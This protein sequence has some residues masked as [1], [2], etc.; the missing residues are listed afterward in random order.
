M[1]RKGYQPMSSLA[2][3][4]DMHTPADAEQAPGE[5][6]TLDEQARRHVQFQEVTGGPP[7]TVA[8]A[9]R[10]LVA[11]RRRQRWGALPLVIGRGLAHVWSGGREW[12]AS[13]HRRVP[14]PA[15]SSP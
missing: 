11:Q 14:A 3:N 7:I 10:R 1:N 6:F 15:R 5:L 4:S 9:R 13:P 2:R 12:W 8:E